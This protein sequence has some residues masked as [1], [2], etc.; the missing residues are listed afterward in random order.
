MRRI[1]ESSGIKLRLLLLLNVFAS[2][3]FILFYGMTLTNIVTVSAMY[4][5]FMAVGMVSTF[6]RFYSHKSFEFRNKFLEYFCTS[7]GLLSGSGSV[8]GWCAVHNKHHDKHDTPEDPHDPNRGLLSLLTLNYDYNIE[9]KYVKYLFKNKFLMF[10]H[11]YYYLLIISYIGLLY[12]LFGLQGIIFGFCMPSALCVV[13]Q[14][15]TTYFLHKDGNPQCVRWMNFLVF[16]DGN[17]SEH[18]QNTKKYKLKY[19]DVS[20]WIIE[21]LLISSSI[22]IADAVKRNYKWQ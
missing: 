7:L 22:N 13:G 18:H 9:L 1:F 14:G 20:G 21:N 2:V 11:K 5:L 6:H 10:T 4:F 3:S 15:M 17:H 19:D 8:F 16:G 12:S